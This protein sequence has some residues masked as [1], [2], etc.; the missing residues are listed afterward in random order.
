VTQRRALVV[1]DS[2]SMRTLVCM[3]LE[4]VGFSTF[5]APDGL[6]ALIEASNIKQLDLVIADLN[7]PAM[8]GIKLCAQLRRTPGLSIV[9]FLLLTT[10]S[11]TQIK[12]K[13]RAAGATGWL[14][15]PF[16]PEQLIAVVRKIVR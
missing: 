9:P 11:D 14:T 3:T 8:D 15:K 12:L 5:Q 2:A 13:A 6:H 4:R 7:M 1:D 16:E 10:E